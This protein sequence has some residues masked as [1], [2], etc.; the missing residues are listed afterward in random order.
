MFGN[1]KDER[2]AVE[3]TYT[4]NCD[5]VR[6]TEKEIDCIT[7]HVDEAVYK[8]VSCAL[9]MGK[10]PVESTD[11]AAFFNYAAKVFMP[12]EIEIMAGDKII[13]TRYGRTIEYTNAGRAAVY[14]THQ[15]IAVIDNSPV[16]GG[17]KSENED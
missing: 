7:I 12:P 16:F 2:A 5:I 1:V 17:D 11:T 8:D 15:E 14:A 9:V 6:D 4:D 13:V 10:S 3:M